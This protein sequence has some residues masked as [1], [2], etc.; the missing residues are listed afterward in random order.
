[1]ETITIDGVDENTFRH[2]I[3]DMLRLDAVDAATERL[4][5]LLA[6]YAAPGGILPQRFLTVTADEVEITGWDKL[7]SR[8]GSHDRPQFPISAIGVV[9]AD[10][11][12]LGGPGP[13]GGR[14]APFIKTY[15]FTD[16][17]YPFTEAGRDDL[18][19][20]Y[21]REG[22]GWQGDYQA[23]DV[24]LAI[25][26]I[27]D[28]HGA[29]IELEDRLLDLVNPPED[30]LRAGTIGACF[31]AA[32]IHQA[33]RDTIHQQGL[34]RP[35]C[36]LAA[37][38]GVYPFFDAPVAGWDDG[39]AGKDIPT[40]AADVWPSE[41]DEADPGEE[42]PAGEASLL[43]L[44]SRRS[45]KH[46]ALELGEDDLREAARFTA[47]ASAQR[48]TM[49]DDNAL[50][51]LFRGVPMA[52]LV[53]EAEAVFA[54]EAP[55]AEPEPIAPEAEV[56]N[57][58]R[59]PEPEPQAV[60]QPLAEFQ[61]PAEPAIEAVVT[62]PD[63][64]PEPYDPFAEAR[65]AF[66]KAEE[67]HAFPSGSS[68]RNRFKEE[69]PKQDSALRRFVEAARAKSRRRLRRARLRLSLSLT[70]GRAT[71]AAMAGRIEAGAAQLRS[72]LSLAPLRR[73]G[74]RWRAR[75]S[76]LAPRRRR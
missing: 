11:R 19:D 16:D 56:A 61:P 28:L 22:F 58:A 53:E 14:L 48:L 7:A 55:P 39:I 23:S 46:M 52:E 34:P 65:T 63:P 15:Y 42:A 45:V 27:D 33:L 72:R 12:V 62:Q 3:E 40:A 20:G 21:T 59:A 29:I 44:I 69:P 76:A 60:P 25:K 64:E 67:A 73:T 2:E 18:L 37:C 30:F 47:D 17:A 66:R 51:G 5:A 35:L 4:R 57:L 75:L 9:L 50:K 32:L 70:A 1:M 6:P 71:C 13:Q 54:A 36:V 49:T 31:L 24:T 26:G 68:L 41:L 74:Q 38:D 10:A 43:T 8:L